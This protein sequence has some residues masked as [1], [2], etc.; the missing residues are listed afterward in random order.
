M[1]LS[2]VNKAGVAVGVSE[3]NLAGGSS[4]ILISVRALPSVSNSSWPDRMTM[5]I[6][7]RIAGQ[8]EMTKVGALMYVRAASRDKMLKNE[9][10]QSSVLR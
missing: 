5:S 10:R 7:I 8:R 3:I 9:D 4:E 6:T 1:S 2:G